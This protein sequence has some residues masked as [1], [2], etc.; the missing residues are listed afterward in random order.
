[1]GK[2]AHVVFGRGRD[3]P[4]RVRVEAGRSYGEINGSLDDG[5]S[6]N[7]DQGD[8]SVVIEDASIGSVAG[9]AQGSEGDDATLS[10]A[11]VEAQ[12][13]EFLRGIE[14]PLDYAYALMPQIQ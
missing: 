13:D 6:V 2:A 8:S 12:R 7:D 4:G 11:A 5:G 1:A 10:A 3:R 9:G 14:N